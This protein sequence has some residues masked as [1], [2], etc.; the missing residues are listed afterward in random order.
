MKVINYSELIEASKE[1]D[2]RRSIEEFGLL[3][4][5][6]YYGRNKK[7]IECE[8]QLQII[9]DETHK[10]PNNFYN[11]KSAAAFEK[12]ESLFSE[13]FGFE[14]VYIN[15]SVLITFLNTSTMN[16]N[17]SGYTIT[18][19][20]VFRNGK[21]ATK[22]GHEVTTIKIDNN[23]STVK[24][25]DGRGYNCR[26]CIGASNFSYQGENSL[27][28]R[29]IL[30][31]LL[32]EIGHNFYRAPIRESLGEINKMFQ[33]MTLKEISAM[34]YVIQYGIDNVSVAALFGFMVYI[35]TLPGMKQSI[36]LMNKALGTIQSQLHMFDVPIK[37]IMTWVNITLRF[38]FILANMLNPFRA[39]SGI[40]N[41]DK[42][43]YADAF[44]AAYGYATDLSTGL[45]KIEAHQYHIS[46][47]SKA[48][49]DIMGILYS[50]QK[51][52]LLP[53]YAFDSHPSNSAR[54]RNVIQYMKEVEAQKLPPNIRKEFEQELARVENDR[55]NFK[56]DFGY[57]MTKNID[58]FYAIIEDLIHL[59]D[60]KDI[61]ST[62]GGF[63]GYKNLD[64]F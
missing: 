18:G 35:D 43:K 5:A 34:Q 22:F 46:N 3:D 62:L 41:Y 14:N 50:F 15:D 1:I 24:L 44:S 39:V 11:S 33:M 60:P 38:E 36:G 26:I 31:I 61:T 19:I 12:L 52:A 21:Y 64:R 49:N 8:K 54:Q 51:L 42:E 17:S 58:I 63:F 29:E 48:I 40:L 37:M 32:H 27:T 2:T 28:A 55:A 30:A 6:A 16:F 7:L 20:Y 59:S 56:Q 10:S 9:I 53:L 4:E 45:R 47:N 23:H 57:D 25:K 13:I